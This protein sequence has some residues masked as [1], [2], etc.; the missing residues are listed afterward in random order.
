MKT[1]GKTYEVKYTGYLMNSENMFLHYGYDNWSDVSEKKM[2]K[3]KSCYKIEVTVP[4]ETTE[5]N[6]CFRAGENEWDNN[7]GNNWNWIP[8]KPESYEYVE[9]ADATKTA[10]ATKA[11]ATT[12]A[13]ASK[14][15]TATKCAAKTKK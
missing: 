9:I 7:S 12:K 10:S 2:R 5:L 14:A 1:I 11:K 8:S 6:F 4:A 3:L 15:K 13:S